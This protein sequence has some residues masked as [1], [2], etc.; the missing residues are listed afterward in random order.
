MTIPFI[1]K[2]PHTPQEIDDMMGEHGEFF[3][4]CY[5]C[6]AIGHIDRIFECPSH[7]TDREVTACDECIEKYNNGA[8]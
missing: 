1:K 6:G 5:L 7:A 2:P 4:I 8:S 3:G